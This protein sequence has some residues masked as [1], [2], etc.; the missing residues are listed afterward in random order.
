MD[1]A[2][3]QHY[4]VYK[5]CYSTEDKALLC[6]TSMQWSGKRRG[7]SRATDL[8]PF[9]KKEWKAKMKREELFPPGSKLTGKIHYR[10][11]VQC[12]FHP[13]WL[14]LFE[15]LWHSSRTQTPGVQAQ[16]GSSRAELRGFPRCSSAALAFAPRCHAKCESWK[17]YCQSVSVFICL[18]HLL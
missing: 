15:H 8:S 5:H 11:K 10:C 18:V 16:S 3:P 6:V 4:F 13:S 2:E 12:G 17:K 7:R 1:I 9:N 14:R